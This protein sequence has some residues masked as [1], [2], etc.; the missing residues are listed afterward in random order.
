MRI[1]SNAQIIASLACIA[2]S[3]CSTG[4]AEPVFTN[5]PPGAPSAST[6]GTSQ[7]G[8]GASTAGDDTSV[9]DRGGPNAG[10]ASRVAAN[11]DGGGSGGTSGCG[12]RTGMRGKTVRSLMVSGKMRSYVAYLPE[13]AN[14]THGLPFVYVFHGANQ[15]GA[16][17]YDMTEYSTLADS[18]GIAV[19]FPDGQGA[20]SIASM[21]VLAPWN[22]SDN[23]ASVCGAGALANNP[24]SSVD[25]AFMDA[26]K[27]DIEQ[28]QCLD[29]DHVFATG[30][31]MGGYFT[32]HVTCDRP[33]IRAGAPHSG[34]TEASLDGCARAGHVPIIIFHGTA[35]PLIADGCDDP[36]GSAQSGFSA[37]A[38]L[39]AQK[40]GCKSTY[41]TIPTN[42]SSGNGQCYLYD[43]CPSDGKVEL[44][45]FTNLAHAWAGST[46][47][48]SC[49]GS[50]TG[51]ASA[52]QLEWAFFKKYAW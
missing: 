39:W 47:C 23:G 31:S 25:F 27:A 2:C 7:G 19:V 51:Y 9:P 4:G 52:T 22:V 42:G 5:G 26:I 32:H 14:P 37:A 10:D 44:C 45:T 21:G 49:I 17:L 43:G 1:R 35:D 34:G 33:D 38:T 15:T 46:A 8:D 16:N 40:N 13:A 41:S 12:G 6:S 24:T 11:D 28:D 50:G 20:S 18:E 29:N 30:F 48:P 3:Q 36:N